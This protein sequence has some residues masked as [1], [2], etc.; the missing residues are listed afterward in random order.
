MNTI[1]NIVK[2]D[3]TDDIIAEMGLAPE[4]GL[5]LADPCLV[6]FYKD[7]NDRIIWIDK[8]ISD[9]LFNEIRMILQWN[10][11][12]DRNNIPIE[13]RKRI[14]LIIH[15]Y[16]GNLDSCFAL[17]DVINASNTPIATVNINTAMSSGCLIFLNGHKGL[18]YC[19]KMS[20]ALIHDGSG[21]Q[22]GSFENVVAQTEN[23]KKIVNMMRENIIAHTNIDQKTLNK[24]KNKDIYLYSNDQIEKGIADHIIENLNEIF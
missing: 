17:I 7:Y 10:R 12:D 19:T 6:S 4:A 21:S 15:S 13:K 14:T 9:S 16:G 1:N 24:W 2:N 23:Y 22:G 3:I 8:D 20:V 18:R 5:M 11:D